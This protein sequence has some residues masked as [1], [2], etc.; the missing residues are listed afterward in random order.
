MIPLI[1]DTKLFM[2]KLRQV[3]PIFLPIIEKEVRKF[4]DAKSS[5]PLR[6]FEWVANL[7]LVR[8]KN[9]EISL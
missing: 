6:Y 3:N 9:G 7:V 5:I 4:L 8:E 1:P 2:K